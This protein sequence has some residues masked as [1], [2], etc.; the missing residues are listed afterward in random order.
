MTKL[1]AIRHFTTFVLSEKVTIARD[2][3][4]GSNF[5]MGIL[6]SNPRLKLPDSLDYPP[7]ECDRAFRKDF[8]ERCP[9]ARGFSSI[10]LT[11]LHECGHWATRSIMDWSEYNKMHK[12]IHSQEEYMKIPWEHLA[13]EWAICWLYSPINRKIAKEFEKDYF[14]YGKE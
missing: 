9:L 11:L 6:S 14:G 2:R 4:A 12:K 3:F 13:T 7:D 8:I 1:Q 10:T 5:G